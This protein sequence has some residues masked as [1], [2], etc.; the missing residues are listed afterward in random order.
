MMLFYHGF[1][2]LFMPENKP[3]PR[4]IQKKNQESLFIVNSK[5]L[6]PEKA[7]SGPR[8][9]PPLFQGVPSSLF[10]GFRCDA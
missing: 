7:A 10:R 3:E 9:I 4:Q 1:Y 6:P 5:G 2:S 8:A